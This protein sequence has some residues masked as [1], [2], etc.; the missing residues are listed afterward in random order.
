MDARKSIDKYLAGRRAA[1]QFYIWRLR[2]SLVAS[3]KYGWRF[4]FWGFCDNVMDRDAFDDG[5]TPDDYFIEAW[6]RE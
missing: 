5:M 4:G 6:G 2:V 1:V 3:T